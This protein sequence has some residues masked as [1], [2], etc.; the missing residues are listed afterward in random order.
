MCASVCVIW[1]TVSLSGLKKGTG[2]SGDVKGSFEK[3]GVSVDTTVTSDSKIST[4]LA[5]N[6]AKGVTTNMN[7]Y[8]AIC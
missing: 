5:F 1:Q 2:V 8:W 3:G 7:V 6:A 4:S